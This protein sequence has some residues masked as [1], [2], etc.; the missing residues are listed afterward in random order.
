MLPKIL[1]AGAGLR[2]QSEPFLARGTGNGDC[3]SDVSGGAVAPAMKQLSVARLPVLRSWRVEVLVLCEGIGLDALRPPSLYEEMPPR[4]LLL[5]LRDF[6]FPSV[7]V[8]SSRCPPASFT[9]FS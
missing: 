4:C 6:Y 7:T 1:Q 8:I 5:N 2:K 9:V 3:S